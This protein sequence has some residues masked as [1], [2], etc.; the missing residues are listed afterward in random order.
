MSTRL[1]RFSMAGLVILAAALA[2]CATTAPAPPG[3][4]VPEAKAALVQP[5][6]TTKAQLLAQLGP[7][8]SIRFNNGVEVWRYM[9][10]AEAGQVA[11]SGAAA[12]L[13]EY[14]VVI[15]ADGIVAKVRRSPVVYQIPVQK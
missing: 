1:K 14:V 9:L 13:G 3:T 15:G 5:G 12:P 4:V 8:G 2:G 7:T 6:V 10:P 11:P